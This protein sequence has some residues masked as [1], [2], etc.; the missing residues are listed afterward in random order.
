[1]QWAGFNFWGDESG[2]GG[3]GP[4]TGNNAVNEYVWYNPWL[5]ASYSTILDSGIA[6]ISMG[7]PLEVGWNTLS[8]PLPL[9]PDVESN[10]WK[11]IYTNSSLA[12]ANC[13]LVYDY[14]PTRAEGYHF[15]IISSNSPE[16]LKPLDALFLK[17]TSPGIVTIKISTYMSPMPTKDLVGGWNFIGASM[18]MTARELDMRDVLATVDRTPL[19]YVGYD[20]VVSP[21]LASQPSWIYVRGQEERVAEGESFPWEK[22][23]MGRGYWIYME[24]IDQMAGFGSTPITAHVWD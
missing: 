20:M 15:Q 5:N 9:S 13:S 19:G 12:S 8:T 1:M 3:A 21:P 14:D 22:M 17:V 10:Q 18:A 24:N 23:W 2:P 16:V 6:D 11:N 4:G 7:I